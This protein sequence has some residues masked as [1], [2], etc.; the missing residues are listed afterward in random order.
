MRVIIVEDYDAMG[1][2]AAEIVSEVVRG[3]PDA[4][5]GLATGSSPV[6]LYAELGRLHREEGLDF[7]RVTTFNLDEYL[8]LPREHAQS[9]HLF[10]QEK[11]FRHINLPASHMHLPDGTVHGVDAYCTRYEQMIQEAGG[12][13]I[14][15]LGI[16]GDGH[17][18]FNEP[19]SSLSSRMRSVVLEQQTI[20]DNARFFAR[21]EDVPRMAITM[22]VGTI[23]EARACLLVASGVARADIVARALEGPITSQVTASAL[24]MHPRTVAVLDEAASSNLERKAYY[25]HAEQVRAEWGR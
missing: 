23:L 24:Q 12:I 22:G 11:L 4:V 3:K 6:G 20:A 25:H 14:Q 17:I 8:G 19:G 9:Y 10:M 1:R 16:G 5:L 21:A 13:D 7:S 18:G 15:V 2:R